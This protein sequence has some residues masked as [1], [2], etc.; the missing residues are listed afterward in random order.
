MHHNKFRPEGDFFI[1]LLSSGERMLKY[2]MRIRKPEI[3]RKFIDVAIHS[4]KIANTFIEGLPFRAE[5]MTTTTT[6]VNAFIEK[7]GSS[8]R[9]QYHV[10]NFTRRAMPE[11]H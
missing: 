5:I 7:S 2:I 8:L 11:M 1:I 3:V 10:N 4:G 6:T 9:I